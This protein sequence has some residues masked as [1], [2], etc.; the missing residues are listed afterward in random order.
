MLASIG[1]FIAPL[2]ALS[3]FDSWQAVAALLSGFA[4]KEAVVS[5]LSVVLPEGIDSYFN[6]LSAVAFLVF[7]LLYTP[8]MAAVAATRREMGSIRWTLAAI[9][10]QLTTAWTVSVLVFQVGQILGF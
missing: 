3:G 8:C 7:T 9:L 4:A 1:S 6:P 10:F 5:T 2:F